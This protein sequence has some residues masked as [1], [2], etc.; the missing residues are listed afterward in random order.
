MKNIPIT[1]R[2]NSK[3]VNGKVTQPILNVGR[4]EAP[5]KKMSSPFKM[6]S[7]PFKQE[8]KIYVDP[9][10]GNSAGGATTGSAGKNI[11][12]GGTPGALT[13]KKDAKQMTNQKWLDYI[14]KE[15]PEAKKKRYE[16]EVKRGIR[17]EGRAGEEAVG[18]DPGTSTDTNTTP[19]TDGGKPGDEAT[20]FKNVGGDAQGA[21]ERRENIRNI[22]NLTGQ[23]KRSEMRLLRAGGKKDADGNSIKKGTQAYKDEK[24]KIKQDKLSGRITVI[25]SEILNSGRQSEENRVAST[26]TGRYSDIKVTGVDKAVTKGQLTKAEQEEQLRKERDAKYKEVKNNFTF[27]EGD[28][29]ADYESG[30]VKGST[31]KRDP[32]GPTKKQNGFFNK[33][34]PMKMKYFK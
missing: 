19:N 6:M 23:K 16:N 31:K 33:K 5:A 20:L 32:D 10:E 1:Q 18:N 34:S 22:K 7:S 15:S 8:A 12:G 24:A 14:K 13:G 11:T 17:E 27:I 26:R 29:G 25:N 3:S 9:E 30:Q 21:A 28:N 2:V 4:V